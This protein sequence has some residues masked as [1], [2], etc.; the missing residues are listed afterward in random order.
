VRRTS[1]RF[2]AITRAVP[3]GLVLFLTCGCLGPQA[4]RFSR[5]RY[6][7]V[8]QSGNKEEFLL[9]LVR[10]H[11]M[12]DPGF[13]PVTSLTAQFEV[14]ATALGRGGMDRGGA[15]N[16]GQGSLNFAD[17]PTITFAPQR[18]PELTKGLLGQIPLETLYL[19]AGNSIDHARLLRLFVRELNG[20]ENAG[21]AGGPA[22]SQPPEFAEF[23]HIADLCGWCQ[24]Q[25]LI[26][27]TTE[28]RQTDVP[29]AVTMPSLS[30]QDLLKI[31]AAGQGV[32]ALPDNRGYL[33]TQ[34]KSV[35]VLRVAP[36]ALG[37]PEVV[38]LATALHLK[39]G[40]ASYEVEEAASGQLRPAIKDTGRTKLSVTTRSVLEVMYLLSHNIMTPEE[41]LAAGLV[42]E[43]RNA[44]G[45]SFD[46]NDVIG[47]LFRVQVCKHRPKAA[48]LAVPYRG[49]WFY[50]DDF[51]ASSKITLTLFSELFRLQR[52]GAAEGQPLLTLPVGR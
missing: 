6:N 41:H 45:S 3:L 16:Y 19:F 35:R 2:Q 5:S 22:P 10:L 37:A 29:G 21:N 9:N 39:P 26:V 34:S 20:I 27:L 49:Y 44:D 47:D 13:L 43:T 50:I 11:Y 15:S 28:N 14:D 7:E 18:S 17:R 1:T 23:R 52:L 46:W 42:S 4:I 33:L 36:D 12:E 48:Y 8:I 32:R 30:A 51:D 25:R 24:S 31:T 40:H 38:E